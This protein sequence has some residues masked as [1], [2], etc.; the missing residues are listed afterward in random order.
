MFISHFLS[1]EVTLDNLQ[2]FSLQVEKPFSALCPVLQLYSTR[3][4]TGK[5]TIALPLNRQPTSIICTGL[6][7][8][9]T[10]LIKLS[11]NLIIIEIVFRIPRT[12]Q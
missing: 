1:L 2:K 12:T 11:L 4:I 9:C 8:H 5:I 10:L 6:I 7:P 3:E